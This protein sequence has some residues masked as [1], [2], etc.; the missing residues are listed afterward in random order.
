MLEDKIQ[1]PSDY[2]LWFSIGGHVTDQISGDGRY[3]GWI[4]ILAIGCG[5]DFSKF[6][7]VGCENLPLLWTRFQNSQ[8][9]KKVSLKEQKTQ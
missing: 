8:F 4:E 7:D 6:W 2:V 5:K 1:K 9:K 3:I